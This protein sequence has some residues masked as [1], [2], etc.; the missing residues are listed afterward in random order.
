MNVDF[1]PL[2]ARPTSY[3]NVI[4]KSK[5]EAIFIRAVEL[6]GWTNWEYEPERFRIYDWVPDFWITASF[7]NPKRAKQIV[8]SALIEYKPA[9]VTATYRTELEKRFT[10]I[11]SRMLP[12]TV[13]PCLVI[14]NAFDCSIPR[15]VESFDGDEWEPQTP[16]MLNYLDVAKNF[17]FD[18]QHER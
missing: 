3:R 10:S 12:Y 16:A 18:L 6:Y 11:V 15:T 2:E 9:P 17:R 13:I 4:L 5:S 14:G 7:Y 1:K 8:M